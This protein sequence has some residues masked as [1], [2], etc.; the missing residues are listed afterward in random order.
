[1]SR[2]H[3]Y[4]DQ[5]HIERARFYVCSSDLDMYDVTEIN[6]NKVGH[7]RLEDVFVTAGIANPQTMLE[8][9]NH[10]SVGFASTLF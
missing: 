10:I 7:A 9:E 2:K 8:Q 6:D 5:R 3:R 1:M 4:D